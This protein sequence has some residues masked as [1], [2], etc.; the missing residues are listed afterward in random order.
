MSNTETPPQGVENMKAI[1]R[2]SKRVSRKAVSP[3]VATVILVLISVVAGVMLWLWVSGFTSSATAQQPALNER[4]K[5]DSVKVDKDSEQLK[6]YV[7]NVGSIPVT[8]SSVYIVTYNGTYVE[9][10][11]PSETTTISP[12]DTSEITM[13]V[14]LANYKSGVI[15]TVRV[16]TKNGVEASYNFVWPY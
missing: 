15:Y 11:S 6:V 12:G 10:G 9:G 14:T 8:I 4:I 5:I 2:V 1:R 13:S 16:V 3:I 7:R